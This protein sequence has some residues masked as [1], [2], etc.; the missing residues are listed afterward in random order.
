MS[1]F[2]FPKTSPKLFEAMFELASKLAEDAKVSPA[3]R[4]LIE[5]RVSHINECAH[6][7]RMHSK[8]Y[9]EQGGDPVK[10]AMLPLWRS[11]KGFDDGERA[12]LDWAECLTKGES[13][14]RISQSHRALLEHFEED[15]VS[16]LTCIISTMNAWNRLGIAQHEF[17]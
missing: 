12:A 3:L 9:G 13:Q 17:A 6:C 4:S 2:A 11:S 5:C 16:E 15:E 7:L 10:L 8:S 14:S 1:R